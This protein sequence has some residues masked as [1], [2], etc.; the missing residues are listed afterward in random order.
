MYLILLPAALGLGEGDSRLENPQHQ[1][2]DPTGMGRDV[3]AAA[4]VA[5]LQ[6]RQLF[7]SQLRQPAGQGEGVTALKNQFQEV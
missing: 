7:T 3:P 1:D 5:G 2:P 4:E 6:C